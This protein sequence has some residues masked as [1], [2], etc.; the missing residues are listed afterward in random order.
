M[1]IDRMQRADLVAQ[2]FRYDNL[3]MEEAAQV[4]E[5][6]TFIPMLLQENSKKGKILTPEN[7]LN[8]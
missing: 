5:I 6:E 7:T 8:L 3:L 4:L 1:C 2:G